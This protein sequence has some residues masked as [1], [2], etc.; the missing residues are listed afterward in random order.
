VSDALPAL[1][2]DPNISVPT[3]ADFGFYAINFNTRPGRLYSDV[4]LR[5]AF[6]MCIDHDATVDKA[7]DGQGIPLSGDIPPASWAYD[8]NLP[9]YT[10]DVAGAKALI[11]SAGWSLGSDNVY[12]KG[13]TRLSSTLYVHQGRPQRISFG[14]LAADQLKA[15]G[16]ELKVLPADF[17]TV[18]LPLLDYPNKF[19]TYLGGFSTGLDPDISSL[20]ACNQVT[21]KEHPSGNNYD[22]YCNKEVDAWIQQALETT[23]QAARKDLYSK[24]ETQIHNDYPAYFLWADKGYAA[25]RKSVTAGTNSVVTDGTIDLASPTYYWNLD[26]WTVAAE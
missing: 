6:S 10:L 12:A 9:K 24:A 7:T 16:I 22:G 20:W 3:Y 2:A 11:E 23:D 14:Q 8:Q 21:T 19:D 17:A 1:Q 15:C 26:T 25:I 4:K 18:L 13:G 5:Q